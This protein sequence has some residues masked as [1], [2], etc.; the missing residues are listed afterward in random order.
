MEKVKTTT[1]LATIMVSHSWLPVQ[2]LEQFEFEY[3][4][5]KTPNSKVVAEEARLLKKWK[6]FKV[7]GVIDK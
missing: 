6:D 2:K 1:R 4:S 5:R 7:V 3:P